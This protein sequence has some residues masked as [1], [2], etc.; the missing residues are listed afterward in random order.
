MKT[1][2]YAFISYSSKDRIEAETMRSI[3]NMEG[4]KTWM[5]PGDIPAGKRYAQVIN[6]AIKNCS[7]F[8]LMLTDAAQR[9]TWVAKE[10]ER[11]VSCNKPIFSVKI[12]ETV[13]NDEFE[14]Y[15]STDQMVAIRK[16]DKSNAEFKK[17]LNEI[18]ICVSKGKVNINSASKNEDKN[19]FSGMKPNDSTST[20]FADYFYFHI[21]FGEREGSIIIVSPESKPDKILKAEIT[22]QIWLDFI[23]IAKQLLAVALGINIDDVAIKLQTNY[24]LGIYEC[25]PADNLYH[26]EIKSRI[27]FSVAC[28]NVNE[29]FTH[30]SVSFSL[31]ENIFR[32]AFYKN[33]EFAFKFMPKNSMLRDF[34]VNELKMY[35]LGRQ[36]IL[37]A[38]RKN[39]LRIAKQ[40]QKK[41]YKDHSGG[42][43]INFM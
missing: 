21:N 25:N 9:S 32:V 2:G 17:L 41:E 10:T 3:L 28:F 14:L 31:Y 39:D 5:A 37:F 35:E 12:A 24:P 7:C 27:H 1:D 38:M 20:E 43:Y 30:D 23:I 34:G 13:L 4:I 19:L 15:L 11:A 36:L 42:F 16:F 33:G 29:S 40:I 26:S 8:I 6:L 22:E 18:S